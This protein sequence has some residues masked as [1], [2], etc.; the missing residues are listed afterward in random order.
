MFNTL[1]ILRLSE[2][3]DRLGKPEGWEYFFSKGEVGPMRTIGRMAA[4][5]VGVLLA[6]VVSFFAAIGFVVGALFIWCAASFP[7]CF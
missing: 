5:L 4:E 3:A 6:G 7:A 1:P 2:R